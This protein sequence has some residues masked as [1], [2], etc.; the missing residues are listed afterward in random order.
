MWLVFVKG[1][2][3][4]LKMGLK[5]WDFVNMC[6]ECIVLLIGIFQF[7]VV[8]VL[9]MIRVCFKVLC[10]ICFI[11]LGIVLVVF[12]IRLN[13]GFKC[14]GF[15]FFYKFVGEIYIILCVSFIEVV[16]SVM[17]FFNELL[18]KFMG[19]LMFIFCRFW[20]RLVVI[21]VVFG[22]FVLRLGVRLNLG[23]LNVIILC[24][25]VK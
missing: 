21:L 5:W 18:I 12:C 1:G 17:C 10:N 11:R 19:F 23:I 24:F 16:L 2:L 20:F 25:I 8:I 22:L 14:V 13:R 4:V 3:K 9:D 15:V 6:V 7:C